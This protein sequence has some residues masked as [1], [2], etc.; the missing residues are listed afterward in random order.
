LQIG[1]FRRLSIQRPAASVVL[2][3]AQPEPSNVSISKNAHGRQ[4]EL[5][6]LRGLLLIW[7]TLT[8]LPTHASIYSNQPFGFVSAA[9]GFIFLSAVLC[10]R[11]F[12][13]KLQEDG[14]RSV[15]RRLWARAARLYGY[16]LCLLAVAFT[17]IARIAIHT[18][19]PSLQGL[20][21]FYLAHPIDGLIAS[22][23]LVYRPPLLDILPMYILFLVITPFLLWGGRR[24]GWQ[25]ILVL[26]LLLWTAAQF[27]LRSALYTA[28]VH[29][30]HID[31]PFSAL[32]AFDLYAWQLLWVAG[33][34]VGTGRPGVVRTPAHPKLAFWTSL[35]VVV[36]LLVVRHTPWW[37]TWNAPPWA[38]L[39]D[40]WHLGALRILNFTA[41]TIVFAGLRPAT[42]KWLRAQPWI[43]LGQAS[44]EVF[45]AHLLVCFAA[46]AL[47]GD[48]TNASIMQQLGIIAAAL[49][50][51]YITALAF[52]KQRTRSVSYP[53]T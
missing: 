23:L 6:G 3:N 9:E 43:L 17:V 7:M 38:P 31:I 8:H 12:G 20:V 41:V 45:C 32:G 37:D 26:S 14:I 30:T 16:H 39:T 47:V 4:L 18:R 33:V 21:D 25:V 19:Q 28:F 49:V 36:F 13:R 2:S 24:W 1:A 34:W 35:L 27:G 50:F 44:L 46:L 10:G 40:K 42:I 48:G 11:I 5:D 51:L 53:A 22:I 52:A 15:Q 29:V